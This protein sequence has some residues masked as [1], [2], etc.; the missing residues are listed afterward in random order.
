M[1]KLIYIL[2]PFFRRF[3][4]SEI[5][6]ANT[7]YYLRFGHFDSINVCRYMYQDA[8]IK[9]ERKYNIYVKHKD[10]VLLHTPQKGNRCSFPGCSSESVQKGFCKRHYMKEYAKKP[11]RKKYMK[12]YLAEYYR[13][14][15]EEMI[16]AAERRRNLDPEKYKE[17]KRQYYLRKKAERE[18]LQD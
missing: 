5:G 12:K 18:S 13:K 16:A 10:L 1:E 11:Q 6:G 4:F 9:L 8:T 7:I 3:H 15:R 14:H 2:D 17:Q